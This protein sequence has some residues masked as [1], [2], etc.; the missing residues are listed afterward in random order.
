MPIVDRQPD[1]IEANDKDTMV[2]AGDIVSR[3]EV[4]ELL[5]VSRATVYGW[6]NDRSKTGFPEPLHGQEQLGGG[7]PVYHFPTVMKF[8]NAYVRDKPKGGAP[9]KREWTE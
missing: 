7:S 6:T 2:R 5:G 3:D 8:Y 9:R 1:W 4:A